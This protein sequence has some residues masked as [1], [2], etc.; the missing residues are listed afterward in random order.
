MAGRL[1]EP[2][3]PRDHGAVHLPGKKSLQL[4]GH[5]NGQVGSTVEHGQQHA[6]ERQLR[7]HV[8]LDHAHGRHQLAQSLER[9]ILA[10]ER[11]QKAVRCAQAVER[12]QAERRRAVDEHIIVFV[13]DLV[14]HELEPRLAVIHCDQIELCTRKI[15]VCADDID[16]FGLDDTR[17]RIRVLGY[18]QIIDRCFERTRIDAE[19]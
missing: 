2:H 5:L 14:E 12:Q 15:D 4:L 18:D 11:N 8:F 1:A 17:F 6:L 7:V 19:A 9:V 16:P 3:V 10:L 13:L